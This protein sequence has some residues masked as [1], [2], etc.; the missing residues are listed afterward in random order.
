MSEAEMDLM[1]FGFLK[2]YGSYIH[3]MRRMEKEARVRE[4]KTSFGF[5]EQVKNTN[6]LILNEEK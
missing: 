3:F 4:N 2:K 1:P 6:K 5:Y